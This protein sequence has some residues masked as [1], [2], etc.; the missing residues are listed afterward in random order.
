MAISKV[1]ISEAARGE[2]MIE[3][4]IRLWTDGISPKK[5]SVV[6]KHAWTGGVIAM[7]RNKAHGIIPQNPKP[8][9]SLLDIGAVMEKVLIEHDIQLHPGRRML[10][11]T[12][13]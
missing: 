1:E 11:Y 12:S 8:F 13:K 6:P 4:K 2:K 7:G 10:K 5:G 9:N 3:I